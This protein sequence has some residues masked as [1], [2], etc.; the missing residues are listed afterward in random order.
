MLASD[1][2]KRKNGTKFFLCMRKCVRVDLNNVCDID[3]HLTTTQHPPDNWH[4]LLKRSRTTVL[5]YL[6]VSFFF[7]ERGRKKKHR[8]VFYFSLIGIGVN[9]HHI[10]TS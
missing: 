3:P 8:P 2:Q 7:L 1:Q 10:C 9:F 6:G 4:K 5:H